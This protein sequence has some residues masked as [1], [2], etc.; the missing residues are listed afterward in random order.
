M[1]NKLEKR[2]SILEAHLLNEK[3]MNKN[4]LFSIFYSL[5]IICVIYPI[6][7]YTF[8]IHE[9]NFQSTI[10]FLFML[11]GIA[12]GFAS[13]IFWFIGLGLSNKKVKL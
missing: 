8:F 10:T 11:L 3:K 2:L 7:Y 5:S 4:I 13:C 1:E 12:L 9:F 6:F